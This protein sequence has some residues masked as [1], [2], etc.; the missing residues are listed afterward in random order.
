[1][2]GPKRGFTL[3]ELLVVIAIIAVLIALLLPAVQA[4][5]EAAR[6][7]QCRNNM[8]Q[9]AL[10]QH[11][12]HDVHQQFAPG[13]IQ[14]IGLPPFYPESG[15][16]TN[17]S[18]INMHVWSEFL[19]PYLGAGTVYD[20]IDFNSPNFSP[21]KCSR[22]PTGGYTGL[23]SGG[24][25][26]ACAETRP[27]AA[28]IPTF[29]CPSCVRAS[30]PFV[31]FAIWDEIAG[32]GFPYLAPPPRVRG[33]S[34]YLVLNQISGFLKLGYQQLLGN[35]PNFGQWSV[36]G[37]YYHVE[38]MST[39]T[40]VLRPRIE[41][42]TDGTQTTILFAENAG[43]PDLWQRGVKVATAGQIGYPPAA[44]PITAIG[45]SIGPSGKGFNGGGCWACWGNAYNSIVGSNFQGNGFAPNCFINCT[46]E[47]NVNA[48]Y[49]FHPGVGGLAMCDGSA[50]FVSEDISLITF[51]RLLSFRGHEP[52]TDAF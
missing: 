41:K 2:S 36:D 52:V 49:S 47:Q 32:F 14:L 18:D 25:C 42:I 24:P 23:N 26:C 35:P 9:V 20:R 28:V 1:M 7:T 21:I 29:V 19:L 12:Y 10:A 30:N 16:W 31:D 34:D 38:W 48:I 15:V 6:R 33:A 5:R 17:H 40:D 27:T 39:C 50:R 43:R 8:K 13:L 46:N 22:I 45:P 51:A 37:L 4:A 3:I 11:N 44:C